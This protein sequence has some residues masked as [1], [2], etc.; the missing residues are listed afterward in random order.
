VN[1]TTTHLADP[2]NE[3]RGRQRASISGEVRIEIGDQSRV[4]EAHDVSS[5]GLGLRMDNPFDVGAHVT[6]DFTV[7]NDGSD[8]RPVQ[9]DAEVAWVAQG[10]AGLRFTRLDP[11]SMSYIMSYVAG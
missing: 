6:V 8:S 3:R 1:G 10:R 4:G 5:G 2:K 11:M 7:P 9:L